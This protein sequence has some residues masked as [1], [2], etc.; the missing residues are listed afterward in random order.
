[1]KAVNP[2]PF[3]LLLILL[4]L[5][6]YGFMSFP[7]LTLTTRAKQQTTAKDCTTCD[8]DA[9]LNRPA[10]PCDPNLSAQESE[11]IAKDTN[12]TKWTLTP[13]EAEIRSRGCNDC[14]S[15]IEDMHNGKISLGCIDCHG[16]DATVRRAV[17]IPFLS[18]PYQQLKKKAHVQ[19]RYSDYWKDSSGNPVRPTTLTLKEDPE[20]MRFVNPGDLRIAN[21]SC[22]TTQCHGTDVHNV[23]RSMMTTGSMLWEAALYNNGAFPFKNARW[24][25][26]YGPD[27][28]Q[29]RLQTSPQPDAALTQN[30]GVLPYIDPLPRWEITQMGN[31]LRTF[32][33]GGRKAAEIGNPLSEEAPG[34]PTQN[35]LSPR[36]LGTILATDPVWLG[37]Q[38]SRLLDP[39]LSMMGTNDQPG[40]YRSSGCTACHVVYANDRDPQH[41]ARFAEFGHTGQSFS[42]DAALCNAQN[43]GERGHP[44]RHQLTRAIPSSQCVV[45][46]VHPGTNVLMTYYGSTWWDLE[47]DAG[48]MYDP[49][50]LSPEQQRNILLRNPE[51]SALRGKWRDVSFLE[52]LDKLNS[53]PMRK[54]TQFADFAGHGWIFRYV[55]KRDRKGNLLD[56]QDNII[57]QSKVTPEMLQRATRESTDNPADRQGLPVH[58]KDIHLEKGMHCVD[59]HFKQDNHG[60]GKLYGE[61]RNAIEIDCVDCHGSVFERADPTS[62]KAR[63]SAAA[64]GNRLL[65]YRMTPFNQDR[66]YKKNGQL[67]Q[68]SAVEQGKEWEVRQIKDSI[69]PANS[70]YNEKAA[71]AKTIHK[72]GKTWGPPR[73]GDALA[74]SNQN[75]TC[76]S[77][78]LSWTP[79]CFGCHLKMTANQEK[80]MLH[81]E[82]EQE[83]RN[84]VA[85]NFQTLRDDVFMLGKDGTVTGRRVAPVRSACAVLVSSQNALREWIYFQQQTVSE[86]GYSGQAFS[87]HFPH[88]VRT[89]ETK[90]CT[91][92]HLS[93][94]NDN[95]AWMAMA[96]M[97]GTNFY[98]FIGRFVYVAAGHEGYEA[99]VATEREEPQAVIGST[100]H[101]IAFPEE[102]KKHEEHH[103]ELKE[104]FEHPGND[105]GDGLKF[106]RDIEVLNLQLRGEYLYAACGKGGFR[107]F[108]VANVDQKGFSERMTTAPFSPLGQKFYVNSKYAT[109]IASPATIAVDP[110]ATVGAVLKIPTRRQFRPEN[111][112]GVYRDDKQPIHPLYAYLYGTDREEGLVV[113]GNPL[114]EKDHGPGVA[115][116]LDG[117]PNNN[118]IKRALAWNPNGLLKGAN[119]I[120]VTGTHA[121]ITCDQGLVIVDISEPL[122][123]RAVATIPLRGARAVQVQ[124]RYAFVCDAEGVKVV[125]V[126]NPAQA[127]LVNGAM[128]RL[129]DARNIYLVRTYA[130][131]AA[132]KQGLAILDIENPEQPK[133][134]Q[135][136]NANGQINDAHDV[137]VG[138]TYVSLFAYIA[139]GHN[140][141]RIVQLTSP[142]ET[143]GNYGF[144][145]RPTPRLIASKHT[146]GPALAISEGIDR[147]RA[148]DED[149][150]QLSVFGR[151]GARPFNAEELLR[152]FM[153]KG[154]TGQMELYT[155][156]ENRDLR[157]RYGAP[158]G[159][160]STWL[161]QPLKQNKAV[162]LGLL[163]FS[164]PLAA[165]WLYRRDRR[166]RKWD[167]QRSERR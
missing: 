1:M 27:G 80:P 167:E 165:V 78:H 62:A 144:S 15:G 125:D 112:E 96:T 115:T 85:Y 66:F 46:H 68:R 157:N 166:L 122:K 16:G 160:S 113:I 99:V 109:A 159:R 88:T 162:L 154:A 95:N 132:G 119:N 19:P 164:L 102:Y 55:F 24:G 58:L 84:W 107:F 34:K 70:H 18:E 155:V 129:E 121:Y 100:M 22:G 43:K 39:M 145:P 91:D 74:H 137:K 35:L 136:Y 110:T 44:V 50:K 79:S 36:G 118:F 82:G 134:D 56:A 105:I 63:T 21:L 47:T 124:F 48:D 33:R 51:E 59:C 161:R 72:D 23:K 152:L 65:D 81:N 142:E 143:P 104:V 42:T 163:S 127:K 151:R 150:N 87:S 2:K 8:R 106:K 41:S 69:D 86:E 73:P 54:N 98:N 133:L 140:G 32:E 57:D 38:K 11:R 114:D 117:D 20:W 49:Q 14:H 111:E 37:L 13:C 3:K 67:Y 75:M 7:G 147:D 126:T 130:Y 6:L 76:F 139:D 146:L 153:R 138:M 40:D 12:R 25:E 17:G 135:V 71:L 116:L 30:K 10:S 94:K 64:G 61:V 97:Q 26:S 120:V 31:I 5:C 123:P 60:N 108:D 77:C 29:Q 156:P 52:N 148:I 53:S 4:T 9:Q 149:G 103:Q 90:G 83:L 158:R 128:V 93:E 45:C 92:C 141:M 101:K 131:V 28:T 89:K